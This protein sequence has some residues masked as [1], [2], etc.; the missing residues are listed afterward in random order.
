MFMLVLSLHPATL[1]NKRPGTIIR[2]FT[3]E[4]L[5]RSRLA[6]PGRQ[7][8]PFTFKLTLWLAASPK[9]EGP[10]LFP[11]AQ[12]P[13]L[14]KWCLVPHFS[15]WRTRLCAWK[16]FFCEARPHAN[17]S[18]LHASSL[19]VSSHRKH[20]NEINANHS[21]LGPSFTASIKLQLSNK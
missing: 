20:W 14:D 6:K 3:M 12:T 17:E 11:A 19:E 7:T 2:E 21:V 8:I 16:Y 9:S 10:I 1:L 13:A 15:C 5:M 4:N 18:V